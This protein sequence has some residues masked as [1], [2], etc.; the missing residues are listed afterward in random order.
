MHPQYP[1]EKARLRWPLNK[2]S[3]IGSSNKRLP[4]L[5]V[6]LL[7]SL[8]GCDSTERVAVIEGMSM[9]PHLYGIHSKLAC[10]DCGFE[11]VLRGDRPIENP[12]CPNCGAA[13]RAEKLKI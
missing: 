10:E 2:K 4:L 13:S 7:I 5:L 1:P 3:P 9:A 6:L 11:A 8:S 12:I